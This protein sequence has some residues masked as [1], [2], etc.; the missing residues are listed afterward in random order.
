[1]DEMK[2]DIAK[3]GG[4]ATSVFGPR[5]MKSGEQII[6]RFL[7]EGGDQLK[8]V[9]HGRWM[10]DATQRHMGY[11]MPCAEL[12]GKKCPFCNHDDRALGTW[13]A[14]TYAFLM[15]NYDEGKLQVLSFR[16]T[17]ATPLGA[18][19]D[20]WE[21]KGSLLKRDAKI[22]LEGQGTEKRYG[23]IPQDEVAFAE[24]LKKRGQRTPKLPP[25]KEVA[26]KYMLKLLAEAQYPPLLDK[27][28]GDQL[29]LPVGFAEAFAGKN[30][31]SASE[32]LL[33]DVDVD[34]SDINELLES[35]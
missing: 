31:Y 2:V 9:A 13:T 28:T 17:R 7:T 8:Y 16:P 34:E 5:S 24:A 33:D 27:S 12:F 25:N 14:N 35:N 26:H 3:S 10:D 29:A 30:G 11:E 21:D 23:V 19:G 1:M 15:W 32:D 6:V 20:M 4:G 18:I 22:K